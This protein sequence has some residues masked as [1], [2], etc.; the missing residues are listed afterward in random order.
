MTQLPSTTRALRFGR[1]GAPDVLEVAEIPVP[2]PGPGEV[3]LRVHAASVNPVDVGIVA[4]PLP[5]VT[6]L[7]LP[8]VPGWDVAGTV[9]MRG[10]G[11]DEFG[12]GDEVFGLARFPLLGRGTFAEYAAV[13]AADLALKPASLS[14]EQAGALPLVGLTALQ[15]F[16]AV[17]GL[18]G[19]LSALSALSA[20]TPGARVLID[21]AAGGVGHIAVQIAA[22]AGATVIGVASAPR[23]DFLRS[24]GVDEPVDYTST[25]NVFAAAAPVHGAL[26]SSTAALAT[27]A[28]SA[29]EP[30]GF[31]VSISPDVTDEMA[32]IA[33]KRGV[34]HA[35]ILVA[36]D[37]EGMRRLAGL[38][39]S[40]RVRPE[41]AHVYPLNRAVEAYEQV[42]TRHTVGK[43]VLGIS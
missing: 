37:G 16:D 29:V 22:A 36:A 26:I 43:V 39:A 19:A 18:D 1:H 25:E 28:A 24:I 2:R 23:H 21:A 4:I 12:V 10:Q 30:G 31:L 8:A 15:A 41:I 3:L 7:Q 34:R 17:G 14:W 27:Q 13:P 9:V 33:D 6:D 11:T 32:A 5:F 40:L 38:A 42:K 35:E 20:L